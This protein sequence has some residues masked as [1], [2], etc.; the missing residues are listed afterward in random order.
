MTVELTTK[1]KLFIKRMTETPEKAQWGYELL[2]KRSDF[3]DFFD[4]LKDAGLFGA[5]HNRGPLPAD[6]PGYVYI[7]YWHALDYLAAVAK[8]AGETNNLQ[9]AEK[10]M[11]V[12]RDVSKGRE[13]DGTIRDN[14]HTYRKFAEI[15]GL[16]PT[17][18]VR[19]ADC[20][21][22]PGWIQ[23]KF[24]RG[25]VCHALDAGL[26]RRVLASESPEDW[27]K[28]ISILRHCTTI[29]W[30]AEELLGEGKKPVTV[31]EDHWL[32]KLIKNH[33]DNLGKRVGQNAA[34]IF[35]ER[36][37]ET[38]DRTQRDLPSRLHRPAVEDHEQNH[39]WLGP[40]NRFVEGLRD[41]LL[42]WSGHEP[43]AAKVFV[44]GLITDDSEILRR[45]GIH[46]LDRRWDK[47][48]EIFPETVSSRLF[49][50][51]H[52]HELYSLLHHHFEAIT[53]EIKAA[54]VTTIKRLGTLSDDEEE[55]RQLR[56]VQR[57]W[58]S[59]VVGKGYEPAETWFHELNSDQSIGEVS[60]H[61]DFHSYMETW[62][63]HG[64]TPYRPQ[65]LIVF[66]ENGS[67]IERLNGFQEQDSWRGPTIRA[68]VD[69]LEAAV[70]LAPPTFLR[71]LQNF[72]D[73]KRPFQYGVIEG[74]KQ[75]WRKPREEAYQLDW[76][77]AWL[78]LVLFFERLIEASEFWA[79]Q[80]PQDQ[81]HTPNRDW[82]PPII[83][84]FLRAGTQDED[85]AYAPGLLARTWNLLVRL[86]EKLEPGN[87]PPTSDA[88]TEAINSSR[89]KVIEAV[90]SHALRVCRLSDRD[91]Q[92]H[93]D[94]W[95]LMKPVF[96]DELAKCQNS[97]YDF[98]TLSA[99][100][101]MN[102]Y[103]ID[104]DWLKERILKIFPREY[105]ANF[106]CALGGLAYADLMRPI[107]VLLV[108]N[109]ILDRALR[110]QVDDR[111]VAERLVE[112]IMLA[113]LWD[114]EKLDS[115][116]LAYIFESSRREAIDD[117]I[118]WFW[119]IRK[120]QLSAEQRE[121]IINF[122]ER[123][124][125]WSR[126][127]EDTPTQILSSLSR[128]ACYIHSIQDRELGLLLA[129]APYVHVVHYY[130]FF[131]EELDR[132]ASANPD[133]IA[134]ILKA[135]LDTHV[136]YIDYEDR[137]KSI[138]RK[139]AARGKRHEAILMADRLKQIP[140]MTEFFKDL[141]RT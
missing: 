141:Q 3:E 101:I 104:R 56:R 64:P 38:Y 15:L 35:V 12:V 69:S 71:L 9:L 106:V 108:E 36:L 111:R 80:T 33:S 6:Q 17:A 86:L 134:L 75:I 43:L 85:N 73:A 138:L 49:D 19:Q 72:V 53:P 2:L 37:R 27:S 83:A 7:P 31:V 88:M 62:R 132:L 59:A 126:A 78:E 107:Y 131:Y 8:R 4:H 122:W 116:R 129:V 136:P 133:Q 5:E 99:A 23:G 20:D 45:I 66:A 82:I 10:V 121:R 128:L 124:I 91:R 70:V 25:M 95:A 98:S 112:R 130:D 119:S 110:V 90:F 102:L 114:D 97:N 52:L 41:V 63:G 54:V 1:I 137:L 46:V 117:A 47:L 28:A 44:R 135:S 76:N 113:Y 65:E 61:A 127:L 125:L 96:E 51:E 14:Y 87:E 29:T 105:Q 93:A 22:I 123:C 18:A 24:E 58:L 94:A 84:E 77:Q 16:V 21:L 13:P 42:S 11:N 140:G 100:Y 120:E 67:L 103:Y 32:A 74:F 26:M 50:D 118:G 60:E 34:N 40:E 81:Y 68:L 115:P 39:R 139:L 48:N 57:N 79:E 30:V 92:E 55:N 89:G 109:G